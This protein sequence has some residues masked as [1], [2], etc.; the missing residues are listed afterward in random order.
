MKTDFSLLKELLLEAKKEVSA[1]GLDKFLDKVHSSVT[2]DRISID[3]YF[4]LG[5]LPSAYELIEMGYSEDDATALDKIN[6][7]ALEAAFKKKFGKSSEDVVKELDAEDVKKL[8][9]DVRKVLEV[10]NK[11]YTTSITP[12]D[13]D[14]RE[15]GYTYYMA[16]PEKIVIAQGTHGFELGWRDEGLKKNGISLDKVKKFFDHFK[17]K[18]N[19]RPKAT[20]SIPPIYD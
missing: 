11:R 20:R 10:F 16:S 9:A 2:K 14:D 17:I 4:D 18:A 8:P 13:M 7:K 5:Y 15:T 3:H 19:K 1:A 12:H 6:Y